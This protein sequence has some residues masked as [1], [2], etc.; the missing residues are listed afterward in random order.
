MSFQEIKETLLQWDKESGEDWKARENNFML[1]RVTLDD[2]VS[3]NAH[4]STQTAHGL[5]LILNELIKQDSEKAT[6]FEIV[7]KQLDE[8]SDNERLEILHK[9][10]NFC[11]Y[12]GTKSLQCNCWND[13]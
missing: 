5:M 11:Q 9:L 12:C 1:G 13:D 2:V 10:V 8:C 3:F 6:P 7:K 4:R